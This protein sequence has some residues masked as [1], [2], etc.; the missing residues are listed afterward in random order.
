MANIF[1]YLKK[2]GHL[3]FEELE[4]NEIDNLIFSQLVYINFTN[5]IPNKI[6]K[7]DFILL[8]D[9]SKKYFDIHNNDD[10]PIG[11]L[12]PDEILPMLKILPSYRRFSD[13]KLYGFIHDVNSVE[14]KQFSSLAINIKEK[15]YYIAF[16]GTDD[17]LTGWRE[18][19]NMGFMSFIPSQREALKYLNKYL[20]RL[21]G[22]FILGGHSKG[23]NLAIY[24]ASKCISYK[25][26]RIITIYNNDG[27]GLHKKMI[28]SLGYKKIE[29]KIIRFVPESSIVGLLFNHTGSLNIIKST[30]VGLYQHDA[31]SW[32]IENTKFVTT[33]KISNENSLIIESLKSWFSK[34]TLEER[35]EF[36]NS[37]F[38]ILESTDASTLTDLALEKTN[39]FKIFTNANKDDLTTVLKA[40]SSLINESRKIILKN[41][42]KTIKKVD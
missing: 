33:K 12:V 26:K 5:V 34:T 14:T 20:N 13:L 40:L 24:S 17:T 22:N 9:A 6:S 23:G 21:D 10:S 2:Y 7:N 11:L 28:N 25:K 32:E 19:F 35:K 42:S 1:T 8:K 38:D 29:D 30:Q 31:F 3:S 18:D 37:L 16:S 36:I 27:P 39:I 4:F 15:L 41:I